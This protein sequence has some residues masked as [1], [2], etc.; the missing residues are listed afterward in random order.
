M[1]ASNDVASENG[2]APLGKNPQEFTATI[3]NVIAVGL[4]QYLKNQGLDDESIFRTAGLKPETFIERYSRF[5]IKQLA[6]ALTLSARLGD[7]SLFGLHFGDWYQPRVLNASNYAINSAPDIRN[8]LIS[9]QIH[10]NLITG[11][12]TQISENREYAEM[13]WIIKLASPSSRQMID[14][15]AMRTLK[16][17]QQAAGPEWRPLR[18]NLA[19]EKPENVDEYYRLLGPNIHFDQPENSFRID[20]STM[21][22]PMPD[23]DPDIYHMA[24]N[25][26]LNPFPYE[27]HGKHPVGRFRQFISAQLGKKGVTLASASK[28]MGMTPQQLRRMLK[29]NGTCFQCVLDETRKAHTSYYLNETETRFSEIS[30]LLGF[31]DQSTFSRAVKRW[32]S[33]TPREMRR[34]GG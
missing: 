7:D 3:A 19:H 10:C 5:P 15:K 1:G 28:H 23:A 17:I 29:K 2:G 25:S 24:R 14:F 13:S 6:A 32:F 21:E 11:I 34:K 26:I 8:S 12:P 33:M 9:L 31:T 30:F 20:R 4:G 22:I 27:Q 18:V 16:V